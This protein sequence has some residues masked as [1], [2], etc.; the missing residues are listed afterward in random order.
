MLGSV[1]RLCLLQ[2]FL[3]NGLYSL[4]IACRNAD[5]FFFKENKQFLFSNLNLK[6]NKSMTLRVTKNLLRPL[7][8]WSSD[9]CRYCK[10]HNIGSI[11]VLCFKRRNF[12]IIITL[13]FW[14]TSNCWRKYKYFHVFEI[15]IPQLTIAWEWKK[16][17]KEALLIYK[18]LTGLSCPNSRA[19]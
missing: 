11:I 1:I 14:Y 16:K 9:T 5:F 6:K 8:I 17:W 15:Q 13:D 4:K 10:D 2:A 18:V 12:K 19:L 7:P 3:C